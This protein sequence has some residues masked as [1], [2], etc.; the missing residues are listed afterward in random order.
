MD[1]KISLGRGSRR[2][3]RHGLLA[4]CL[5]WRNLPPCTDLEHVHGQEG[6]VW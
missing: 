3:S 4:A 2:G 1:A 6:L 5:P